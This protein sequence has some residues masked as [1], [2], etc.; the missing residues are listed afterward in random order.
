MEFIAQANKIKDPFD[1]RVV[2]AYWLGND[3]LKNISLEQ[4]YRH[5]KDR[6]KKRVSSNSLR[7]LFEKIPKGAKPH[8]SFHVLEIYQKMGSTKGVDLGPVLE[9]INNCLISWGK[10]SKICDNYLKVQYRPIIFDKGLKL[11]LSQ[12]KKIE[13]KY[14]EKSFLENPKMGDWVSIHWKW[15]CDILDQGELANL[16][17]WTLWHLKLTNFTI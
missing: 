3:L 6:F 2:E 15:A 16:Q 1:Y 9:T 14:R 8:H 13:Y 17:R 5:L 11:G 10:I 7:Y 12:I 4:F